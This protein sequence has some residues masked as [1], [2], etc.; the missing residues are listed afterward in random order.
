[1]ERLIEKAKELFGYGYSEQYIECR[2]WASRGSELGMKD[3]KEAMEAAK[4]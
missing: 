4:K 3:I 1:M 2:L